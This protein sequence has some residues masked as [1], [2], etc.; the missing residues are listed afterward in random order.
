VN[1]GLAV[2]F[3]QKGQLGMGGMGIA[4]TG[5]RG[6]VVHEFGHAFVGLLD[7]Y[8]VNPGPPAGQVESS[9]T[10]SVPA[11]PPWKHFL[12]AKVP[13]VGVFEG[14]ATFQKGVWRPA[15]S[16]AMNVGGST[17]C[18]VC[19]ETG[20]LMIYSYVSPIDDARPGVSEVTL[21]AGGW[22]AFQ[23][24]PMRPAGHD[25][26]VTWYLDQAPV[27]TRADEPEAGP[28]LP[29][30]GDEEQMTPLERR[31][32]ER[33]RR[34]EDGGGPPAAGAAE[35]PPALPAAFPFR[36]GAKRRSA[37]TANEP[38]P[39]G[40]ELK[41]KRVKRDDGGTAFEPVLPTLNP[42][43]WLLTAVVRDTTRFKGEKFP[44]VLK[45]ERGLLE[46]RASWTLVV[47]DTR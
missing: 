17:Y 6:V 4:T 18:P 43:R 47:P 1:D 35:A 38:P 42:G 39:R 7:E 36:P 40:K 34:R 8:A 25:L 32:R 45:D 29:G 3:A 33:L 10:T 20:V 37:G 14:G 12:D 31:L 13:G 26:E 27:V 5:P 30:D 21:G 23:V 46:D 22:P 24:V 15:P 19:R 41:T 28:S 44:W 11:T 9:N 16:C 2:C